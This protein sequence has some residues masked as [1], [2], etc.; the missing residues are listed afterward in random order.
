LKAQIGANVR[1]AQQLE[2]LIERYGVKTVQSYMRFVRE[3]AASSVRHCLSALK[4]GDF[5]CELDDGSVIAVSITV[6][7]AAQTATINFEGTSP[8]LSNNFN[9]PKSICRAAVM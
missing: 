4:D 8:Q 7:R 6:D 2:K 5:R 3:N 1:G 9:A